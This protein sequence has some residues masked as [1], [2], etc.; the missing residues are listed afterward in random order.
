MHWREQT[1]N[2]YLVRGVRKSANRHSN[3]TAKTSSGICR[4]G[5]DRL[6]SARGPL[7]ER[8]RTRRGYLDR[9]AREMRIAR[10]GLHPAVTEPR[11]ADDRQPLAERKRP[12]DEA[13][14]QVVKSC[15][16]GRAYLG[17]RNPTASETDS[18]GVRGAGL[19]RGPEFE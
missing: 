1:S 16:L 8:D 19:E 17:S 3:T 7:S 11:T 9:V 4:A 6:L 15:C 10:G 12:R 5:F 18:T 13:V 14:A 2:G